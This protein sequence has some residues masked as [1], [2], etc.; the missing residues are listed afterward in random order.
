M[1]GATTPSSSEPVSMRRICSSTVV[2]TTTCSCFSGR[3]S[4]LSGSPITLL[5]PPPK[6][7]R[8]RFADGTEVDLSPETLRFDERFMFYDDDSNGATVD[9]ALWGT[10]LDDI[11]WGMAGNDRISGLDGNDVLHGGSHND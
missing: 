5:A 7:D 1:P 2:R 11:I 4:R 10:A 6:V 9:E 3:T 8:I